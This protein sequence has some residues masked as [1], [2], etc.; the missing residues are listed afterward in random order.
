MPNSL[1]Q[2]VCNGNFSPKRRELILLRARMHGL[3][4]AISRRQKGIYRG[5]PT[6]APNPDS[7]DANF[8]FSP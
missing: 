2:M 1:N 8:S 6:D 4:A 3:A 5:D 7:D